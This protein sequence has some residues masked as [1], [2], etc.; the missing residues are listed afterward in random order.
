M[1]RSRAAAGSRRRSRPSGSGSL[2][3]SS[4]PEAEALWEPP[5]GPS[6]GRSRLSASSSPGAACRRSGPSPPP[7]TPTDLVAIPAVWLAH[8]IGLA[9]SRAGFRPQ[10]AAPRFVAR[11]GTWWYELAVG[12]PRRRDARPAPRST[13][14]PTPTTHSRSRRSSP[15]GTRSCTSRSPSLPSSSLRRCS[16]RASSDATPS[17]RSRAGSAGRSSGSSRSR[18]SGCSISPGISCSGSRPTR[19]RCSARPTSGSA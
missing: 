7:P 15:R 17:R 18:S 12:R 16:P 13:A 6:N 10:R 3:S 5:S 14:G 8:A 11:T 9:P 1:A 4:I 2:P 19:R